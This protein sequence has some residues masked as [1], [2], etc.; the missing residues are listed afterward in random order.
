MATGWERFAWS[1]WT[2][3][4]KVRAALAE[5]ADPNG[6]TDPFGP[7]LHA[8][9]EWDSSEVAAE[10][11]RHGADLDAVHD[12]RTA[13]WFAV[14]ARH[15]D[16]ARIL[17]EA[18][19]D[20]SLAPSG[21][22]PARLCL[23]GPTP[24]LFGD[25]GASLTDDE[26]AAMQESQRLIALF[27]GVEHDVLSVACVVGI[28]ADEATRRLSATMVEPVA[29]TDRPS[30]TWVTEVPG[31]CVVTQPWGFTLD[32]YDMACLLSADTTCYAVWIDSRENELGSS[33]RDGKCIASWLAPGGGS[34]SRRRQCARICGSP[35][36]AGSAK[37][38][39]TGWRSPA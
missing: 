28:D 36:G 30:I 31:G 20:P 22:S 11:V 21:W 6:T 29:D 12:G 2:D 1:D 38:R 26:V 3:L 5:G 33:Y 17:A 9:A 34:G 16:I 4:E 8:A 7:V 10:L 37:V 35:G 27:D 19:A 32:M 13:L 25:T 24:G 39:S 23:A 15:P 14:M 18:G